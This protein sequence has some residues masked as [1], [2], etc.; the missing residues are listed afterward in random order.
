MTI[1]F[2]LTKAERFFLHY[3]SKVWSY[4]FI[5]FT[6]QRCIK[7]IK[8]DSKDFYTVHFLY[9]LINAVLCY[10]IFIKVSLRMYDF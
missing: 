6:K 8:S 3:R 5:Y 9:I 1:A 2:L 10:F 7:L 4:L